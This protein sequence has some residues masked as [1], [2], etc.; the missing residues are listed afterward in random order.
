[1]SKRDF[2]EIGRKY[3]QGLKGGAPCSCVRQAGTGPTDNASRAEAALAAAKEVLDRLAVVEQR[4]AKHDQILLMTTAAFKEFTV[5]L[6]NHNQALDQ[7][8]GVERP[9][10]P[11]TEPN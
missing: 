2:T 5:T 6:L 8:F 10:R 3:A 11:S 7:L 9:V 1:M 4:L